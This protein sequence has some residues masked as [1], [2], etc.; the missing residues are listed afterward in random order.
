MP[1]HV[2]NRI[3]GPAFMLDYITRTPTDD[4]A[5]TYW[6]DHSKRVVDFNLVLPQPENIETGACSCEHDEGV[7]CW[8]E[9][10]VSN[11]G[12]KWNGYRTSVLEVG[13]PLEIATQDPERAVILAF[14]TAWSHPESVILALSA[15]LPEGVSLGVD[16][17]DEDLGANYGSYLVGGGKIIS[18]NKFHYWKPED[19]VKFCEAVW[20]SE[21]WV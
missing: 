14:R 11:W 6:L 12:T 20:N 16:Y 18:E 3:I 1:N 19:I 9:W 8:Y 21:G 17:A 13:T 5:V 7:V 2:M 4:E 15:K 10:N